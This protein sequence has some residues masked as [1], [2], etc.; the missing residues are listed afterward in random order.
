MDENY[1]E[2]MAI[3][4]NDLSKLLQ[5]VGLSE[6]FERGE[7]LCKFC[8]TSITPENL[9]SIL[10]ESGSFNFVCT[11]EECVGKLLEHMDNK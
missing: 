1:R 5:Q 8:K 6:A 4:E 7:I 11:K 10:P 9:Y 2:L 3:H